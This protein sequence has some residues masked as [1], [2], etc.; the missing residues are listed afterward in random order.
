MPEG[1]VKGLETLERIEERAE[2]LRLLSHLGQIL[3]ST[4]DPREVRKRAMEAATQLMKAEVGSLLLIDEAK[5]RLYFEVALGEKGEAV[6]EIA[7]NLGEGIA[8]WV[9]EQGEPLIVNTPGQDLRF[10]KGVDERTDFETRNLICVPVKIKGRTIGVLE[11]INKRDGGAFDEEDLLLLQSLSDQVA[12]ALDNARLYQEL[13]EMFFETA[14]SLADAIEKRDPYTGGHT[15]RVTQYSLAIARQL[16]W[17]PEEMKWLKISAAL[18]DI[19]KIGIDDQILRKPDRLAPEE[20]QA[21]KRHA[22]LGAEIIDHI[23]QL[24]RIVPGI[25]HHHEQLDGK[26]YPEGLRGAEIPEVAKIIAVAD[27]Y[28]AMTTDRPYRKGMSK[29]VAFRELK[30]CSGTQFDEAVVQAFIKAYEAGEV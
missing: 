29:E 28:D 5:H 2:R 22:A 24:K 16:R 26:G 10:Y 3:N 6:K 15:K 14:E 13:E 7:L 21:I 18:H 11:A 19:G 30:R 8:G 4:L 12:I 25:R 27:T 9:A 17:K 20:Y 1:D 23:K